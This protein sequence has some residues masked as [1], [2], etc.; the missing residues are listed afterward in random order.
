LP[1]SS[2]WVSQLSEAPTTVLSIANSRPSEALELLRANLQ[3]D[4]A[5][6]AVWRQRARTAAVLG[7]CPR[8]KDSFRSGVKHW[9]KYIAITHGEKEAEKVAFPPRLEDVL[10]WSNTFRC[11]GTFANYLGYL[12]AACHASGF[13]APPVGHPAIRRAM[14]AIVKRELFRPRP[15]LFLQK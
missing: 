5:Y 14:V 9:I 12:R 15:K 1:A 13:E 8:S 3:Q 7:S 6:L 10:A 2:R 11:F 4:P